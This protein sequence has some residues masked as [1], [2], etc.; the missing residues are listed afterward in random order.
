MTGGSIDIQFLDGLPGSFLRRL[1]NPKP[2]A[3]SRRPSF[4]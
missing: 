4:E 3:S 2:F 1:T